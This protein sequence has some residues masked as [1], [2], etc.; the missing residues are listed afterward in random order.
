MNLENHKI[1]YFTVTAILALLIASPALQ[2]F[3]VYPQTEFFTELWLLGPNQKAENYPYNITQ[4]V[5][6]RVFLGL[7]NH[8]GECSYYQVEVKLRNQNTPGPDSFQRT[9][10]TLPV[11][12]SFNIV[13]ADNQTV[14]IPVD[15]SFGYSPDG[16][17]INFN[18]L[19]INDAQININGYSTTL[20]TTTQEYF[21][22]LVFELYLYNSTL[23]SF[24]YHERFV[25]LRLNMIP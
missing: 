19:T 6:N 17:Q 24:Q 2:H 14:Q 9:P 15:F 10:S 20:N 22:K 23:G 8:L 1:L 16:S 3:L 21:E 7:S 5:N 13:V 11:L 4:N 12:Y 18:R 25:D